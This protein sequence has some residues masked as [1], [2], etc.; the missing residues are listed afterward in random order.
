MKKIAFITPFYLPVKLSGSGRLVQGIA[1]GLVE[2]GFDCKVITA[3]GW[4]TRS[5]YLPFGQRL[6]EKQ[7]EFKGVKVERL[8]CGWWLSL[9]SLITQFKFQACGPNLL[10]LADVFKKEK[11]DI[12][13]VVPFP[14][15][16]NWL[17]VKAIDQLKFK[18]RLVVTPCFHEALREYYHPALRQVLQRADMVQALTGA[19]KELLVKQFGL[20]ESKIKTEPGFLADITVRKKEWQQLAVEFKAKHD[21]TGKKTVLFIGS[22][23]E[24]KGLAVLAQAVGQLWQEDDSYRLVTVG[25]KTAFWQRYKKKHQWKFL[26]DLDDVSEQEKEAILSAADVFCLPSRVESFG[27]VYLEAWLKKKPVIGADIGPVRELI[28]GAKGGRLVKFG[29]V[30]ELA[31][32]I[33]RLVKDRNLAG[34]LGENGYKA[35]KIRYSKKIVLSQLEKIL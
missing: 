33:D 25:S 6:Q 24:E 28:K 23:I 5:W 10:G 19:E 35:L 1:E 31:A 22:K 16:L 14:A 32:E 29:R 15:Y 2:K 34:R 12:V 4:T 17:V 27:L 8:K 26:V 18:P 30:R 13:W 20:P 21:L 3:D 11:F 9:A 7:D